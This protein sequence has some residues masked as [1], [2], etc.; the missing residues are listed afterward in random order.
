MLIT[1]TDMRIGSLTIK[2]LH[3]HFNTS[4]WTLD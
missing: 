1:I 4:Q 3:N 2:Q